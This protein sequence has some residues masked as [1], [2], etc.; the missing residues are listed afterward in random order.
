MNAR[1]TMVFIKG[2][3]ED[4][5]VIPK[6]SACGGLAAGADFSVVFYNIV[7][8]FYDG[9]KSSI[10][11]TKIDNSRLSGRG[12]PEGVRNRSR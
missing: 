9:Q 7:L 8:F 3:T 11:S 12:G 6:F 1:T 5:S 10:Y 2:F 4:D